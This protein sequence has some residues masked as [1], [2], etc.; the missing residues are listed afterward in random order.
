MV[1]VLLIVLGLAILGGED[2]LTQTQTVLK[3]ELSDGFHGNYAGD[4]FA[5]RKQGRF[6]VKSWSAS[7]A[8]S[9]R[10]RQSFSRSVSIAKRADAGLAP[11]TGMKRRF[12]HSG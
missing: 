9:H 2:Q 1:L 11:I 3:D 6:W 5:P 12:R 7:S 4:L 10:R 8:C